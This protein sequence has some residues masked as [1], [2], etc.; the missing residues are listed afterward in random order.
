M[1]RDAWKTGDMS[2]GGNL[3]IAGHI[4]IEVNVVITD[5]NAELRFLP[6]EKK[7]FPV[8]HSCD[9]GVSHLL[10]QLEDTVHQSF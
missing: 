10:L 4:Y 2:V 5:Q 6:I 7:L 8:P 1:R 9:L 3:F